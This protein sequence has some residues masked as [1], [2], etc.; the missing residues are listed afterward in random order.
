MESWSTTDRMLYAD[1]LTDFYC[2]LCA[3]YISS[4]NIS[5]VLSIFHFVTI[6]IIKITRKLE[7]SKQI[8][9]TFGWYQ[10]MPAWL[11]Q[12]CYILPLVISSFDY[13]TKPFVRQFY[14]YFHSEDYGTLKL[15]YMS[16][17]KLN[18]GEAYNCYRFKSFRWT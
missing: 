10:I 7:H 16:I 14:V 11:S 8:T 17:R 5:H 4:T 1:Q 13:F 3:T 2:P 12:R 6:S 15:L 18:S 9:I